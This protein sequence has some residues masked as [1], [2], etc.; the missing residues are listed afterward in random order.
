MSVLIFQRHGVNPKLITREALLEI[1]QTLPEGCYIMPIP[2]T[3]NL[4][5]QS[6][7]VPPKERYESGEKTPF[8]AIGYI[9]LE[10]DE[11]ME[12]Q[13]FPAET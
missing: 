8:E 2:D 7:S 5:V 10:E 4:S 1:L 6:A 11:Y 12:F 3:G 13:T 9:D